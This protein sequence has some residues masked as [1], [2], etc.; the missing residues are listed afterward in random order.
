ME[1]FFDET[2]DEPFFVE[3]LEIVQGDERD[4]IVISVGYGFDDHGKFAMRFGPL[5]RQGGERRLNVA[6]THA[7]H[8]I[9]VV[10]SIR[11]QDIDLNRTQSNGARLLR[12]YLDY[13]ERGVGTLGAEI[14]EDS[15][16]ENDSEFE[17]Q[18][19]YEVRS[20]GLDV[21]RQVGCGGY[22]IDLALVAPDNP[23]R[24]V[25][26]I[27]CDGEVSI[28]Q[29]PHETEIACAEVLEDLGWHSC[30]V[31][32]TDSIAIQLARLRRFLSSIRRLFRIL[33]QSEHPRMRS[34]IR[35]RTNRRSR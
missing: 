7:K 14:P 4:R 16:R 10:S 11:G 21:R 30:R 25:L 31:W 13:A 34:R 1:P 17:G 12:A 33:Q 3:N 6:I 35:T 29:Q 19:E 18:V 5:N 32:S 22:R 20:R 23:G 28:V 15:G 2:N 9:T 8:G 26:G 27:E 24:Y